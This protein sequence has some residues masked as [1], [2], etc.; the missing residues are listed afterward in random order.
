MVASETRMCAKVLYTTSNLVTGGLQTLAT[1]NVHF[2]RYVPM[3][4]DRRAF[5]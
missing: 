5:Y 3:G 2:C 1:V 4:N